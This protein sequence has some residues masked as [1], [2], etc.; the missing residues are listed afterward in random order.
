M[1]CGMKKEE[2]I[3]K[4]NLGTIFNSILYDIKKPKLN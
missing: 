1:H 4:Y 2:N 3:Y